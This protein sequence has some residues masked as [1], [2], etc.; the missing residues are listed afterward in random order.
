V[1]EIIRIFVMLIALLF[2][3]NEV[4][5]PPY[6]IQLGPPPNTMVETAEG[7]MS[8][9]DSPIYSPTHPPPLLESPLTTPIKSEGGPTSA[10]YPTRTPTPAP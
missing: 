6:S 5:E 8:A 9:M 1:E 2:G 10:Y 7:A 4:V 3:G